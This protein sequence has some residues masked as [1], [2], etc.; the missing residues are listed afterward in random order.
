VVCVYIMV[1]LSSILQIGEL[2]HLHQCG[3]G[4]YEGELSG[5]IG[6]ALA[7]AEVACNL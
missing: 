4:R 7:K 1:L 5:L 2:Y 3:A 6:N